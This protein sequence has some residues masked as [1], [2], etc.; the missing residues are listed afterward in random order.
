MPLS[1]YPQAAADLASNVVTIIEKHE[2]T[3][4]QA[5]EEMYSNMSSETFKDMRRVMPV[6][7]NK[8]DWNVNAHKMVRNLRK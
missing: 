1:A 5:L 8:F 4:Q 3:I 6:T 7:R 2:N